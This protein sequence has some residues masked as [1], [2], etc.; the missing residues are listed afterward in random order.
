MRED[1]GASCAHLT[2]APRSLIRYEYKRRSSNQPATGWA[3]QPAGGER[4]KERRTEKRE[5]GALPG[6]CGLGVWRRGW[7]GGESGGKESWD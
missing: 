6:A 2:G 4:G 7:V 1:G 5:K 3:A